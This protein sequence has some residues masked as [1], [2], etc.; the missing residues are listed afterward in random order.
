MNGETPGA[1]AGA[2]REPEKTT[3]PKATVAETANALAIC[4]RRARRA[5]VV[6]APGKNREGVDV[7]RRIRSAA[8]SAR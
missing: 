8:D 6:A 2:I 1:G 3:A 7:R 5:S 4:R